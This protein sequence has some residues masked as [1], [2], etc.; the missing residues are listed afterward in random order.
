VGADTA[1]LVRAA[2]EAAPVPCMRE[3]LEL[4]VRCAA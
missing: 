1:A 4:Y 2:L 3:A